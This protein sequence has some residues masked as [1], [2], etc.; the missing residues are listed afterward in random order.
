MS[1]NFTAQNSGDMMHT[2]YVEYT[3]RIKGWRMYHL[4]AESHNHNY[5][6]CYKMLY[7]VYLSEESTL[8]TYQI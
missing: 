6:Q 2:K 4:S 7:E 3:M 1:L 5:N 8:Q